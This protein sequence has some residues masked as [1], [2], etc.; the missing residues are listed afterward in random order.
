MAKDI[1]MLASELAN[2]TTDELVELKTVLKEKHGMV[3]PA[4]IIIREA[5]DEYVKKDVKS[6]FKIVLTKVS[7]ISSEKIG[8]REN[9]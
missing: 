5:A 4:P 3:E 6:S 1:L 2:L 7:E 9:N 8:C